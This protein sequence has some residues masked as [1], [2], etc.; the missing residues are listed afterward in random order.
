MKYHIIYAETQ[1]KLASF[2]YPADMKAFY[3]KVISEY[4]SDY[5]M[6]IQEGSYSSG[7]ILDFSDSH[8]QHMEENKLSEPEMNSVSS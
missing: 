7:T 8:H 6:F 1:K 3:D 5:F 2:E 4:H